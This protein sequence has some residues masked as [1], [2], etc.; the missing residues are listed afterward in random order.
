MPR[1]WWVNPEKPIPENMTKRSRVCPICRR[2]VAKSGT[3]VA[4]AKGL[5]MMHLKAKHP[6]EFLKRK[7]AKALEEE[8]ARI[9]KA[10]VPLRRAR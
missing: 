5:L 1:G 9:R 3:R 4:T 10:T 8:K 6:E 2:I 7:N